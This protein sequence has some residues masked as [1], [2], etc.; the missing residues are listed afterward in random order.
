MLDPRRCPGGHSEGVLYFLLESDDTSTCVP[1]STF[2]LALV[3]KGL[4]I[5]NKESIP[6]GLPARQPA[7][8][9]FCPFKSR[10]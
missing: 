9:H 5:K 2:L 4:K 7:S 3:G 8:P 1:F 10:I 6:A